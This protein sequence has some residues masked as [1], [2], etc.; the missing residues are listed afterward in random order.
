MQICVGSPPDLGK[1]ESILKETTLTEDQK[2][3]VRKTTIKYNR[4]LEVLGQ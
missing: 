4:A 2:E 3:I 1:L